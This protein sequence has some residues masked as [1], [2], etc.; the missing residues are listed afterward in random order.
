MENSN[1]K[2]KKKKFSLFCCFSTNGGK[3]RRRDNNRSPN[4]SNSNKT[5]I[6]EQNANIKV[7]DFSLEDNSKNLEKKFDENS[8]NSPISN[9][10]KNFNNFENIKENDNNNNQNKHNNS[11]T[12]LIRFNTFNNRINEERILMPNINNSKDKKMSMNDYNYL[13][14]KNRNYFLQ[15]SELLDNNISTNKKSIKIDDDNLIADKISSNNIDFNKKKI[16]LDISLSIK[17]KIKPNLDENND[18]VNIY[19]NNSSLNVVGKMDQININEIK[20]INNITS[21]NDLKLS[22]KNRSKN[23]INSNNGNQR[24]NSDSKNRT[25]S[26]VFNARNEIKD[27]LIAKNIECNNYLS[28]SIPYNKNNIKFDTSTV[29]KNYNNNNK[30]YGTNIFNDKNKDN[31][32]IIEDIKP[33][34]SKNSNRIK[35]SNSLKSVKHVKME[36]LGSAI[37]F[38]TRTGKYSVS[39]FDN[40]NIYFNYN[41]HL[42][43]IAKE[44]N[45]I[46]DKEKTI[47][48][49]SKKDVNQNL[50]NNET[51]KNNIETTQTI[52]NNLNYIN[53][54][55]FVSNT[56]KFNPDSNE[57]EKFII[58]NANSDIDEPINENKKNIKDNNLNND[59]NKEIIKEDE[60][61]IKD[62]EVEIEDEQDDID[63]ESR[64]INDSKSIISNYVVA[65]LTGINDLRSYAPSLCSKSEFKDNISN[66]NDLTSNKDAFLIPP[67][68]NETEIEIM[69]ENGKEFKSFIETPRASGTYNKRFTHKNINHN[70][71]NI[72]NIKYCSTNNKSVNLKMKSIYDRINSDTREI[73]KIN[74]K[75]VKID[76][77]IKIHEEL[78]KKYELWI[79]KEEEESEFLINMINFLN[80]YRK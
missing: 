69:N 31:K 49:N 48:I 78:N 3:R 73:Q 5:N 70:T 47:S 33:S 77:K 57:E 52:E 25:D 54:D 14:S 7:K 19:D 13:N 51:N 43:K 36:K 41:K 16:Y 71:T 46:N 4:N 64:K 63:E 23:N 34:F 42:N 28:A 61:N 30:N 12:N 76:E 21:N 17:D 79:E 80:S 18:T 6:T 8:K 39:N 9:I 37:D 55:Y 74:E 68:L 2:P 26:I 60:E 53:E 75:I 50:I 32:L 11:K 59:K 29:I 62:F 24:K 22:S 66:I 38:N 40:N 56:K 72:T 58:E 67:G 1:E 45:K 10:K 44:E 65:P 35:Y 20:G 27:N 15:N